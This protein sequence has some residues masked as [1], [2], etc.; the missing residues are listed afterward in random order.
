MKNYFLM[1]FMVTA[2]IGLTG[3]ASE[4]SANDGKEQEN[5]DS[6]GGTSTS[7]GGSLPEDA[8]KTVGI[9]THFYSGPSLKGHPDHP[10]HSTCPAN[11]TSFIPDF[12]NVCS[13]STDC[14]DVANLWRKRRAEEG[15]HCAKTEKAR[16]SSASLCPPIKEEIWTCTGRDEGK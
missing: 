5:T 2:C 1:A 7:E 10:E 3:C 16:S 8:Q 4:N 9:L 11:I 12:G 15:W 6:E 13:K 14:V